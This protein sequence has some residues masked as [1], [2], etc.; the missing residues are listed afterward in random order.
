MAMTNAA[1]HA[2]ALLIFNNTGWANIGDAT[3]LVPSTTAG[4]FYGSL[5]TADP[6]VSGTQ[7]TSEA[8]YTGYGTRP[9]VARSG[10]G[11]TVNATTGVVTNAAAISWP[12]CTAGTST[13]TFVGWGT[14]ATAA[15][16][17]IASGAQSPSLSVS[18][19][20]TPTAAIG[21]I[22]ITVS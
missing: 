7:T 5:H 2:L 12:A 13:V 22:T 21:A 4:S 15:G 16:N 3:G 20:I 6:G 17:L 11:W 14:A 1:A 10:A 9:G 19:G 8:A 18:T